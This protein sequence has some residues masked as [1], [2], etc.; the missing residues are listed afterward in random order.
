MPPAFIYFD[1]G[2]VIL[3]FDREHQYRQM[4]EVAG[5]GAE[6]VATAVDGALT[7]EVESGLIS[8]DDYYERFCQATDSR[9]DA[10]AFRSAGDDFFQLDYDVLP[11]VSQLFRAGHRLGIL[12]NTSESH[13][14]FVTNGQYRVL[15]GY[16]EQ[17]VL[18]YEVGVMKPDAK[19]FA[20]AQEAAGVPADQIFFT[21]DRED[22]VAGAK[23][24]GFDAVLFT[25]AKQ[26]IDDLASRGV[27][28]DL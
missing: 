13:W 4:A 24:A 26:L 16:F 27:E 15:P 2:N 19:I 1:L 21:D 14:Q 8:T 5:I 25:G 22:N 11:V 12:S 20:A 3:P 23:A 9:P 7:E 28:F 18:S 6:Q 17:L 10:T